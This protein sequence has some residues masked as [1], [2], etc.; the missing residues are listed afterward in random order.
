MACEIPA[1]TIRLLQRVASRHAFSLDE[2]DDLV[3]DVLLA[4]IRQN[5]AF[6]RADF[7]PWAS[8]A[9]RLRARHVARTA[10]RR[11]RRE[12]VHV[13]EG[14]APGF[15]ERRLSTDFVATLSPSLRTVALLANIGLGRIEIAHVLG[16]KDSALRQRISGLRRAVA[17]H[18]DAARDERAEL[19]DGPSCGLSPRSLKAGLIK[20]TGRC[21]AI[22]DPDG[23]QLL[24]SV[25][26]V[27]ARHGNKDDTTP[28]RTEC[29]SRST[30]SRSSSP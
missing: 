28:G 15:P 11:K 18:G 3:Q 9:I 19:L 16:V 23:H 13:N 24:F 25:A 14:L 27:S 1:S 12:T 6:D 26:H 8:G 20:L 2:A 21:L 10:G 29:A 4:A 17:K 30:A 22:I 7:L 5:R